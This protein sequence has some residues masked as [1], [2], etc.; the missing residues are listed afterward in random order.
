MTSPIHRSEYKKLG[1]KPT[2]GEVMRFL[3]E[4]SIYGNLG[5]FIGA[6]FSKAFVTLTVGP[7]P[8]SVPLITSI[9]LLSEESGNNYL[10]EQNS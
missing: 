8:L 1:D 7:E 4:S 3:A 10:S 2:R 5:L 9:L 6:G